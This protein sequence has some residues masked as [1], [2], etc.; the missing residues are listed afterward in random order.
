MVA[1]GYGRE[2]PAFVGYFDM[3]MHARLIATDYIE[4]K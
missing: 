2:N 3:I 1:S 4:P